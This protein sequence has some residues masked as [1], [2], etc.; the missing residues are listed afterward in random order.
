MFCVL[1][2]CCVCLQD[3]RMT[4]SFTSG[5]LPVAWLVAEM[6]H[7]EIVLLQLAIY[8]CSYWYNQ[9]RLSRNA[10]WAT[11]PPIMFLKDIAPLKIISHVI[12][13]VLKFCSLKWRTRMCQLNRTSLPAKCYQYKARAHVARQ[14]NVCIQFN[15]LNASQL[16]TY[17]YKSS[18]HNVLLQLAM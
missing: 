16:A 2:G 9:G 17:N 7:S 15:E 3:T 6:F 5:S 1:T 11:A 18:P 10:E 12:Q 14:V 13:F 4:C 8:V